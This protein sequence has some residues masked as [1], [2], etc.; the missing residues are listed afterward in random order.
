MP[1][2]TRGFDWYDQTLLFQ[3]RRRAFL[4]HWNL[5]VDQLKIKIS[6]NKLKLKTVKV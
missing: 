2:I 5:S 1:D 6:R 4:P 3:M